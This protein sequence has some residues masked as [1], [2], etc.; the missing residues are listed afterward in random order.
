MRSPGLH[1]ALFERI[2]MSR[3]VKLSI[4]VSLI[5]IHS[6]LVLS[7]DSKEHLNVYKTCS[8]IH[9]ERMEPFWYLEILISSTVEGRFRM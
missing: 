7:V 8:N 1:Q 6:G 3:L 2:R 9:Q 5:A 4:I